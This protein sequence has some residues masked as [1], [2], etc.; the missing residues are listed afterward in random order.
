[1]TGFGLI[2]QEECL[3]RPLPLCAFVSSG[4]KASRRT[5]AN[6]PSASA[7]EVAAGVDAKSRDRRVSSPSRP[8]IIEWGKVG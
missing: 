8:G 1:M 3:R 5:A 4:G 2:V 6:G 7:E